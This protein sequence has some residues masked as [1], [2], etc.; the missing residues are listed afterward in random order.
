MEV[1]IHIGYALLGQGAFL[2]SGGI[3]R[4]EALQCAIEILILGH[5][6]V[7]VREKK[8]QRHIRMDVLV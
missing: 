8:K 3:E 5:G 4:V 2:Q 6:D 7:C 1:E